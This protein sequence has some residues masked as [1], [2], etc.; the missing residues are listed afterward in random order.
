MR[1]VRA[2]KDK[3]D[4]SFVIIVDGMGVVVI[5]N[6]GRS[7]GDGAQRL[8]SVSTTQSLLSLDSE[9]YKKP[10]SRRTDKPILG[11]SRISLPSSLPGFNLGYT[12]T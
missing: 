5:A 11:E 2:R 7:T 12:R 8:S 6:A 9:L 10:P 4:E 3:R 1:G